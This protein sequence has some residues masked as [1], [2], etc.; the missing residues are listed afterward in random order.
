MTKR[1]VEALKKH[2]IGRSRTRCF[3]EENP[4]PRIINIVVARQT[5]DYAHTAGWS[6]KACETGIITRIVENLKTMPGR[7]AITE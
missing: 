5:S 1:F 6:R 2:R 3:E 7:P 4:L